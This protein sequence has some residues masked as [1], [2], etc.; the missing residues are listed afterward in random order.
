MANPEHLEILKRGTAIWKRWREENLTITPDFVEADLHGADLNEALLSGAKLWD[1]DLRAANLARADLREAF[2]PESNLE[3]ANL[4][5]ADL[6]EATLSRVNLRQANLAKAKLNGTK[7]FG[8]NLFETNLF[9]ANLSGA[10]LS[11]TDLRTAKLK[12]ATLYYTNLRKANM[13]GMDLREVKF[14]GGNFTEANLHG[15][16]LS[17]ALLQ[18]ANFFGADLSKADLTG[19][20]LSWTELRNAKLSGANLSGACLTCA[21]L[22]E[23]DLANAN[24]SGCLIY[25]ISAWNLGLEGANQ[26]NM[27]ITRGDEP[28]ITV[29]DLEVAQFVYLLLNNKKIQEVIDTVG[30]KG[31]L[32]LGRFTGGRITVLER[33][34]NELRKR[35]FLPMVFNFDKPATKDFT[36][37]VRLLA[38]L[39]YFVIA[40][41]TNPRSAPLELQATVPECMIPFVPIIE[42]GE[43]PFPM[44]KDLWI[45]HRDWVFEPIYYSSLERLADALDT[46]I[47]K[48]AELR[49]AELLA[50]K[51]EEM[52]GKHI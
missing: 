3:G 1:A 29:D 31:V 40:D 5:E 17:G 14:S 21:R 15:A 8:A 35:G 12:G 26:S 33:L 37:T 19:A 39:S 2:L 23:T 16:I 34:R 22:I 48:P 43:E 9:E 38:G 27:I 47:I 18:D 46:E 36:E 51:A 32:L 41:I 24:L 30:R 4:S 25:G 42:E 7:L 45:M 52:K 28:T 49:F 44:L 6:S 11:E 10:D 50:R 13:C 20:Y